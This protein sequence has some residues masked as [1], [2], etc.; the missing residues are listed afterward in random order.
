MAWFIRLSNYDLLSEK[1][2]PTPLGAA[3]SSRFNRIRHLRLD[4]IQQEAE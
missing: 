1:T 3:D 2:V 4:L